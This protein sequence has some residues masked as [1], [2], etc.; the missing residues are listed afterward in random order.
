MPPLLFTFRPGA[1]DHIA[2][3]R[4]LATREQ[5]AAFLCVPLENLDRVAEGQMP[6]TA[7]Y[8]LYIAGAQGDHHY[9]AGLFEPYFETIAA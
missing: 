1:V 9:L 6:V 4:N 3:T 7:R 2:K 8:A 5:L